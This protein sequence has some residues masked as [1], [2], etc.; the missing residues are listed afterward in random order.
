LKRILSIS[1]ILLIVFNTSGF[2]F[3]YFQ[4]QNY[5]KQISFNRIDDFVPIEEL[6]LIKIAINSPDFSNEDVYD[7]IEDKEFKYYG[8]MYDICEERIIND[9]LYLY[10]VSDE[11]EDIINN[12][13][14]SYINEKKSDNQASPVINIIKI[15]IT[16]G[17]VPD[18][19][20]LNYS[21]TF[22]DITNQY[23]VTYQHLKED[24]PSPPPRLVS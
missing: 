20:N 24:I 8:N 19:I 21:N 4:L 9:T 2:F 11:N 3:V 18:G 22:K 23:I 6:S 17:L 14:A 1:L 15:F 12:A 7:R 16:I 10:C 5:F 13:F